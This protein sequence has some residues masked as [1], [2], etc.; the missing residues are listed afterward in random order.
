MV[1]DSPPEKVGLEESRGAEGGA[2]DFDAV[3]V[4][5]QPVAFR[6]RIIAQSATIWDAV[7]LE[8]ERGVAASGFQKQAPTVA[9][10]GL[11]ED[12]VFHRLCRKSRFLPGDLRESLY[13]I[14]DDR[15]RAHYPQVIRDNKEDSSATQ[16]RE[17][18]FLKTRAS[19]MLK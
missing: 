16:E 5:P 11:D 14:P 1:L 8:G 9:G 3:V 6:V 13:D 7:N 4:R 18:C 10:G 15:M 2:Q 19:K 12:P 17:S